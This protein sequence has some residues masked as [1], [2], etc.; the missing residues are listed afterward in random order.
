M[1]HHQ[2][3]PL[4]ARPLVQQHG[5]RVVV[6]NPPALP[7]DEREMDAVYDLP[8]LRTPHPA[9]REAIPA[10]LMIRDSVTI[11]RGCFGG[12]TF[13]SITT[14]P[15]PDHL[16]TLGGLRAARGE[17]AGGLAGVQ[18]DGERSRGPHGEHV[19]DAVHEA[20]GREDLPASLLRASEGV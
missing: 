12:C 17:G 16:V 7:L 4:N 20:G 19:P 10:D 18:G 11:M 2:T 9:Y 3:N 14:A 13:C 15:G 1:I 6:V 8:Y 5:D